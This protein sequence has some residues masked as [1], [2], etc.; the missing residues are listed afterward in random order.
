MAFKL[1]E[2]KESTNR[3][4][5]P[6]FHRLEKKYENDIANLEIRYEN[7]E[8]SI[9]DEYSLKSQ[10]QLQLRK[11]E[12]DQK[13]EISCNELI[14]R[15]KNHI[16]EFELEGRRTRERMQYEFE[17]EIEN[18]EG[19][20]SKRNDKERKKGYDEVVVVQDDIK[21]RMDDENSKH[22]QEMSAIRKD[23][24]HK[25]RIPHEYFKSY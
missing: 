6:E 16:S 10:K 4:M 2:I 23:H 20:M 24:E 19:Q 17:K 12:E 7:Q 11:S 9:R 21:K 15:T 14:R 13:Y 1:S 8:R 25:V 18:I 3:A 5:V 22:N